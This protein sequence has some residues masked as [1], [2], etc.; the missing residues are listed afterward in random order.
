MFEDV[1]AIIFC[2]SLGDYDQMWAKDHGSLQN[3]MM[4]SR[5]L[6]ESVVKHP[7]FRD[8]PFVL[9]LNK[10]DVFEEKIN[11][12]P[13]TVCEWFFDFSP[14]KPH[15]ISQSLA[16]QAYYYIAVKFKDLHASISN[17]KLFVFQT[18]ARERATVDDAFKYIKEVVKWDDA[19]DDDAYG[20]VDESF[21]TT[22]VSASPYKWKEG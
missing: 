22:E 4:A 6:F 11:K 9:L 19:K 13:L 2:V 21:Y 12:V 7:S 5:E 20:F 3:K 18:K 16:S 10:Y 1:R 14:V 8:I 17:K 15:N